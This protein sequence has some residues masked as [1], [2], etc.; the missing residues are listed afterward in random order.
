MNVLLLSD[1]HL[2][3]PGFVP[4]PNIDDIP[5]NVDVVVLAGDIHVGTQGVAW[6]K[7]NLSRWPVLYVPGNHEFYGGEYHETLSNLRQASVG[8][9]VQMLERDAIIIGDVRF[10]G[11]TLWTDFQLFAD[12]AGEETVRGQAWAMADAARYM[13]DFGGSTTVRESPGAQPVQLTTAHT[14]AWHTKSRIW[15]E[16]QLHTPFEGKTVVISHHAPCQRSVSPEFTQHRLTPAYASKL[17]SI[18]EKSDYWVH[19]H[20]HHELDYIHGRCRVITKFC[21]NAAIRTFA[22]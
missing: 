14:V 5:E 3:N 2:E 7:K 16:A 17:G 21:S 19:G 9:N 1:L 12:T 11:T 4:Y 6:A 15:L 8:T 22:I 13:A 18:V 10:L 20:T